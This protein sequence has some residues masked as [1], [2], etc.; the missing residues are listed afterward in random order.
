MTIPALIAGGASLLGSLGN[1]NFAREQVQQQEQFQERMSDTAYSRA[2]ADM[3]RAGLNPALMYGS[4]GPMSSPGGAMSQAQPYD[5]TQAVSS[6][7]QLAMTK[8]QIHKTMLEAQ[9]QDIDNFTKSFGTFVGPDGK[10]LPGMGFMYGEG[11]ARGFNLGGN[12]G[13]FVPWAAQIMKNNVGL[14]SSARDLNESNTK[15][16]QAA[17]PGAKVTGS[18]FGGGVD[19]GSKL[20]RALAPA[21]IP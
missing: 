15:L 6:A 18:G 5:L 1:Q 7:A 9:G 20:L 4:A 3:K 10:P 21:M 17:L 12:A 2:V 19:V 11:G 13:T 16:N 8:A 14:S